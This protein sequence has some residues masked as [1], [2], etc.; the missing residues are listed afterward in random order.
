VVRA[1][2]EAPNP[3]FR[4]SKNFA[5]AGSHHHLTGRIQRPQSRKHPLGVRRLVRDEL[6]SESPRLAGDPF[7]KTAAHAATPVVENFDSFQILVQLHRFSL[8]LFS[9]FTEISI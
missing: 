6:D 7:V 9:V 8:S 4:A 3:S 5:P 2:V 1:A